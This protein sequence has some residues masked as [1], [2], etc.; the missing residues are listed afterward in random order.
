MMPS[1][2]MHD[3]IIMSG[4]ITL[5]PSCIEV[6]A[7]PN[8]QLSTPPEACTWPRNATPPA[9]V[10]RTMYATLTSRRIARSTRPT[11]PE[12]SV[13][14]IRTVTRFCQVT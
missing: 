3:P 12:M 1:V 7:V 9:K 6:A 5:N 8:S 2:I 4:S 13:S 14:R 11:K 10:A